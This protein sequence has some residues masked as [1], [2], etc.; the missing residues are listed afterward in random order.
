MPADH[1]HTPSPERQE[2]EYTL[3]QFN[4]GELAFKYDGEKTQ[5]IIPLGP[6]S[7]FNYT[8]DFGPSGLDFVIIKTKSGNAYGLGA[9]VIINFTTKEEYPTPQ[10]LP[11]IDLNEP[12]QLPGGGNTTEVTMALVRYGGK[13]TSVGTE[14]EQIDIPSPFS[15]LLPELEQARERLYPGRHFPELH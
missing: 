13:F 7:K 11:D 9:G 14:G 15:S 4:N 1:N 12:W 10:D 8:K 5:G 2:A 3:V 6:D